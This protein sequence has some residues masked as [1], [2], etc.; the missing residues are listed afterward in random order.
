MMRRIRTF[1]LVLAISLLAAFAASCSK[2]G[3]G[4][5]HLLD[6]LAKLDEVTTSEY[7]GT[8][9]LNLQTLR[10]DA[11]VESNSFELLQSLEQG[12]IA[13]QG[14]QD[15]K[16]ARREADVRITTSDGSFTFTVP[17]IQVEDKI[18]IHIPVI[19]LDGEYFSL[20]A[21]GL[22]EDINIAVQQA[23]IKFIDN[24]EAGWFTIETQDDA[25]QTI[26]LS[27]TEANWLPFLMKVN[28]SFP[29]ILEQFQ[30]SRLISDKQAAAAR[31]HWQELAQQWHNIKLSEGTNAYVRAFVND[32]GYITEL[33]AEMSLTS[34]L[35]PGEPHNDHF[36][37]RMTWDRINEQPTFAKGLPEHVVEFSE[38]LKHL[39]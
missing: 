31:D 7:G 39:P 36:R 10:G 1:T 28:E 6:A 3:P 24:M 9:E 30:A 4:K 11:G 15:R 23:F 19:N 33:E 2:A 18:W 25:G 27:I 16:N 5:E 20:P 38:L 29:Q 37:L 22:V 14:V 13:W 17:F 21:A 12:T 8:L 35:Q 26:T 32:A 34:Q